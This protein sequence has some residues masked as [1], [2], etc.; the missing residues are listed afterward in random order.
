[1]NDPEDQKKILELELFHIVCVKYVHDAVEIAEGIRNL[2][3][4]LRITPQ[5]IYLKV[6]KY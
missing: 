5:P 2:I 1:M 6:F 3:G 4:L